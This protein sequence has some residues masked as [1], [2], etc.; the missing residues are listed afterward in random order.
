L[1]GRSLSGTQHRSRS[2]LTARSHRSGAP[3][4]P[5]VVSR[6]PLAPVGMALVWTSQRPVPLR[7]GAAARTRFGAGRR[8][9]SSR[10]SANPPSLF[11]I[12]A[13]WSPG[14]RRDG[15][16]RAGGRDSVQCPGK[17][18]LSAAIIVEFTKTRDS[19]PPEY[20]SFQT[21]REERREFIGIVLAQKCTTV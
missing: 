4:R 7:P 8:S 16:L 12:T 15:K 13:G 18:A 9:P 5:V 10:R 6:G 19:N 21:F 17:V 1:T 20:P 2:G 14:A 11:G 3:C